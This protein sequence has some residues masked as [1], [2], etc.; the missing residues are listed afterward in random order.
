MSETV[1]AVANALYESMQRLSNECCNNDFERGFAFGMGA[2]L[3]ITEK[4]LRELEND[5]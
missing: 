2:S 5:E 1:K 3:A 4:T